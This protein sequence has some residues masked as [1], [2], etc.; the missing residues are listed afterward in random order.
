MAHVIFEGFPAFGRNTGA[1]LSM[2][3][4]PP[5][6][7]N[8]SSIRRKMHERNVLYIYN[9]IRLF[10]PVTQA[11]IIEATRL[12]N[13]AVS[14]LVTKLVRA[15]VVY[16]APE[17]ELLHEEPAALG[18]KRVPL[19]VTASAG[20]V[21][22][23]DIGQ[24]HL[25]VVVADMLGEV[26]AG[27]N[28]SAGCDDPWSAGY[29]RDFKLSDGPDKL[30]PRIAST[31]RDRLRSLDIPLDS[32]HILGIAVGVP[33]HVERNSGEV[34]IPSYDRTWNR[35]NVAERLAQ[36]LHIELADENNSDTGI[37]IYVENNAN[38][39]AI[40]VWY[41][42]NLGASTALPSGGTTLRDT[43]EGQPENIVYV[44]VGANIEA[45]LIL[46]GTLYRG[47]QGIA[48]EMG[49]VQVMEEAGMRYCPCGR[50]Y[51]LDTI[52]GSA[53][54]IAMSEI[55]NRGRSP[56]DA[57][58]SVVE[59]ALNGTVKSRTAIAMAGEAVGRVL[60]NLINVLNPTEI[61]LDG[62]IV[63]S[64]GLFA[65]AVRD[66][67]RQGL[68]RPAPPIRD[69]DKDAHAIITGAILLAIESGWETY[70]LKQVNRMFPE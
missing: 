33:G 11:R 45:G 15:G 57:V 65:G 14:Q 64:N 24:T 69:L 36:E 40:A 12:S 30:L 60:V 63:H 6:S 58:E 41:D 16:Q 62:A 37:N 46:N 43:S 70:V 52:A 31:I 20:Y 5:P 47:S 42:H 1:T 55:A 25:R 29:T 4:Y 61:V 3:V 26:V 38:L 67:V 27:Q 56:R 18:R 17:A 66:A 32:G 19:M 13:G 10:G 44:K 35:V 28:D 54:V 53:A 34:T 22:A 49:H 8:E 23:I 21:V 48:G 59:A 2:R 51:C 9:I 39:G 50:S 68:T 7:D